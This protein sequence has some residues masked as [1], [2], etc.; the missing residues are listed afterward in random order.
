MDIEAVV[1]YYVRNVEEMRKTTAEVGIT[2][3]QAEIPTQDLSNTIHPRISVQ[4]EV[5]SAVM[6]ALRK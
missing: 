4:A 3:V 2:D 6:N 1:A 5:H